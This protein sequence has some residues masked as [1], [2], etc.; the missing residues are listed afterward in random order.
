MNETVQS[1]VGVQYV[2]LNFDTAEVWTRT[3]A[4]H[5]KT[6]T[7]NSSLTKKKKNEKLKIYDCMIRGLLPL[8]KV[9][10]VLPRPCFAAQGFDCV[11][12]TGIQSRV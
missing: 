5:N 6:D 9:S 2:P 11:Q 3:S 7:N 8:R 12:S 1:F 10:R 4:M